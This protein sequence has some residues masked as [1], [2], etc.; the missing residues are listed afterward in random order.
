V[1]RDELISIAS[2]NGGRGTTIR[3]PAHEDRN[4]SLSVSLG[5]E[6][7]IL[8][9]CHAGCGMEQIVAAWGMT[10]RD[11]MPGPKSGPIVTLAAI[12]DYRDEKGSLLYQV[13]RY[14]PKTFKQRRPDGRGGWISNLNGTRR[15]LYRL[16]QLLSAL[17]ERPDRRVL[18][19]EGEK[20]V[21][22]LRSLGFLATTNPGG[23][24]KWRDEYS[25]FLRGNHVILLP[26]NDE[27]GRLHR[28]QVARSLHG[29]ASSVR[30]LELPN[31]L[32]KGD[33][34]DWLDAGGSP[35]E[36]KGLA[37][38]A[39]SW[40]PTAD[41]SAA[42]APSTRGFSLTSASNLLAEPEEA[43]RWLV[44]GMLPHGGISALVAKPKVGKST[45]ARQL[46]V[47]VARGE[48]FLGRE[49]CRGSVIYLALEE[50]RAE[51]RAHFRAMGVTD[52]EVHVHFGSAPCDAV[53]ELRRLTHELKP[54][55]VIVDPLFRLTRVKDVS[56]YAE[57]T[58]ALEPLVSIARDTGAHLLVV[59]HGGKTERSGGDSILG[60]TAIFG[61]VDTALMLKRGER[62]RT[63]AAIQ[64]YGVDLDETVLDF[65]QEARMVSLGKGKG[66]VEEERVAK[67]IK[68]ILEDLRLTKGGEAS[69]TEQE[70]LDDVEG[71]T[72]IKRKALRDLVRHGSAER[73]G[74]GKKGSPF[75]YLKA[76]RQG[77]AE[78]ERVVT[79]NAR[80]LVP[81]IYTER[82]NENPK[83]AEHP[84]QHWPDSRSQKIAA[85]GQVS[86]LNPT[87][88]NKDPA[89]AERPQPEG[90]V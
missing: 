84:L 19:A 57:V 27:P 43:V 1:N 53:D 34:S 81:T 79:Q 65:D 44:D 3:C 48:L 86:D 45:L 38:N 28:E 24:G 80:S 8:V 64:R 5:A 66:E 74:T 72:G 60:S 21:D 49:T 89:T 55:L 12:Y 46:A 16:S 56:A 50:K 47:A 63:V 62:Y 78:P 26:D 90:L 42:V 71:K 4:A 10:A 88:V 83:T 75:T 76:A 67:E 25:V 13:L 41:A 6:G 15:V 32:P 18:I 37:K 51:V 39:P 11:L 23:A 30:I 69:L 35:E 17:A 31:L 82:E 61:S 2:R 58:A 73:L 70:I 54:V 20:D 22:R 68:K 52:E 87:Q 29:R 36:L 14:V 85:V 33:V 40:M 7:R 59:H 9:R 77:S